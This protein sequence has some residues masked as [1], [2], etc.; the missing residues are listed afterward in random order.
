MIRAS[1][2]DYSLMRRQVLSN[3]YHNSKIKTLFD[4]C[5]KRTKEIEDNPVIEYVQTQLQSKSTEL[6]DRINILEKDEK[7]ELLT[8]ID[9]GEQHLKD[10]DEAI[11]ELMPYMDIIRK[12]FER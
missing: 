2:A 11:T 8:T 4:R 5:K 7:Q 1:I 6:L 9:L 10:M 12:D 3:N